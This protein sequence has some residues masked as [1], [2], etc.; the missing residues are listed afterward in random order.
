MRRKE[1][2]KTR[3]PLWWQEAYPTQAT[4][5]RFWRQ[6][7]IQRESF[8]GIFQAVGVE[9]WEAMVDGDPV[10][11]LLLQQKEDWGEAPDLSHFYGRTVELDCLQEWIV[12]QRCKRVAVFGMGGIGK[13][14]LCVRL[15][16]QIQENFD[17]TIWRSLLG[18]PPLHQLLETL[19]HFISDGRE[20][21][22]SEN[23][24]TG[25]SQLI[26]HLQQQRCLLVLDEVETLLNPGEDKSRR[27]PE[28]TSSYVRGYESYGELFRRIGSDRKPRATIRN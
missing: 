14:S 23:R 8:I 18:S 22:E 4:I 1:W 5:R 20:R 27:Q 6:I 17:Y 9:N 26:R 15:F 13:T 21:L 25:I 7:P 28:R 24:Q 19:I 10:S 3:T 16:D 11:E 2:T 12:R